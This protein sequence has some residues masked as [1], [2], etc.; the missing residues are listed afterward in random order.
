MSWTLAATS[1]A[2]LMVG[3]MVVGFIPMDMAAWLMRM[4]VAL[5]REAV[6]L[7]WMDTSHLGARPYFIRFCAFATSSGQSKEMGVFFCTAILQVHSHN[8]TM[9]LGVRLFK[10]QNITEL[11]ELFDARQPVPSALRIPS[12]TLALATPVGRTRY[13]NPAL[14]NQRNTPE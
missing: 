12:G 11:A 14:L 3:V 10:T 2:P 8:I 1:P 7:M 5:M 4:A 13:Q 6:D 9:T